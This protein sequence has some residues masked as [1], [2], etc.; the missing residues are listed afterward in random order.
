M[1]GVTGSRLAG[2][3]LLFPL[4]AALS[5]CSTPTTS[6]V[7]PEEPADPAAM[8]PAEVEL[9][10][11][12]ASFEE[13]NIVRFEVR[14]RFQRGRPVKFYSCDIK[15]PGTA[16]HGVKRMDSW[17]LKREGVIRDGVVLAK[18]PVQTFE[19]V[20]SEA[21]SPQQGYKKISNVVSGPVR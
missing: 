17:E 2:W 14:Y 5:G 8:E 19:I 3:L 11:A 1:A 15:F 13:P 21:D 6:P 10:D 16:N 18:Q 9:S 20:L 7:R 12:K 4:L